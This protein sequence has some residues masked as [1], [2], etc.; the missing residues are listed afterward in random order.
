MHNLAAEKL[1]NHHHN[2][3]SK[4]WGGFKEELAHPATLTKQGETTG[5]HEK[6]LKSIF[7]RP[8]HIIIVAQSGN[9]ADGVDAHLSKLRGVV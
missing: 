2:L 9:A 5:R 3:R 7:F 4:L 8:F 1:F 6:G